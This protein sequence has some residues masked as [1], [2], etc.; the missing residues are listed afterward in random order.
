MRNLI[1][2]ILFLTFNSTHASLL[3]VDVDP[4]AAEKEAAKYR[5]VCEIYVDMTPLGFKRGTGT[6]CETTSGRKFILTAAHVVSNHEDMSF[7]RNVTITFSDGTI[8]PMLKGDIHEDYFSNGAVADLALLIPNAIPSVIKPM[9]I[10]DEKDFNANEYVTSI[11]FGKRG[12]F[13]D[14]GRGFYCSNPKE[15][16]H[17]KALAINMHTALYTPYSHAADQNSLLER[18]KSQSRLPF[19]G[20]LSGGGSGGPVIQNNRIV[21]TNTNALTDL[22]DLRLSGLSGKPRSAIYIVLDKIKNE[23]ISNRLERIEDA[24]PARL[25]MSFRRTVKYFFSVPDFSVNAYQHMTFINHKKKQWIENATGELSST[26]E[27]ASAYHPPTNNSPCAGDANLKNPS[28]VN[29][30]PEK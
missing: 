16:Q 19:E 29:M 2:C 13:D 26:K 25:K 3:H 18:L 1:Y 15:I 24:L 30:E 14:S 20:A 12:T 17:T 8:T 10:G 27:E 5:A 7:Q 21:A 9:Q 11:G 4:Q 23:R 22:I 28:N 6:L